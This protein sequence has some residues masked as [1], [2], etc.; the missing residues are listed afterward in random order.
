MEI[1]HGVLVAVLLIC[2]V[3]M[4]FFILLQEG[5]GGGLSAL[6]GTKGGNI[7]GVSN[8]VRRATVFIAA[9]WM[10]C[11]IFLA[12]LARGKSGET[13]DDL[14]KNK[15]AAIPGVEIHPEGPAAP[16]GAPALGNAPVPAGNAPAVAPANGTVP[17]APTTPK[18]ATPAVE[19]KPGEAPKAEVKP[20]EVKTDA[21]KAEAATPAPAVKPEAEAPKTETKPAEAPKAEIKAADP[22]AEEK[23]EVPLPVPATK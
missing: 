15:Q 21:P 6:Q 1:V 19:V 5:K 17:A 9:I 8:P 7:E 14:F 13:G 10:L 4:T 16:N 3:I 2:S 23:K 22:K 18:D 20:A 12:I 11:A